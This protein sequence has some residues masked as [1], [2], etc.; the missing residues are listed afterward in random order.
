MMIRQICGRFCSLE[1]TFSFNIV[2]QEEMFAIEYGI[3]EVVYPISQDEYAWWG[4]QHKVKL[5]VSVPEYEEVNV[6]MAFKILFAVA[7][8]MLVL[9]AHV[10]GL[11]AI[12][13]LEATVF[14]PSQP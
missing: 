12:Y 3:G 14:S 1:S 11:F 5:N 8:E 13:A 7:D 4:V 9:F 2:L 10:V 6:W